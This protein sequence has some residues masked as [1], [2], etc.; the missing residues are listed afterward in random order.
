MTKK[1]FSVENADAGQV[2]EQIGALRAALAAVEKKPVAAAAQAPEAVRRLLEI[3][4]N[5][6]L[7]LADLEAEI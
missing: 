1:R 7:R 2:A 5:I 3:I 6:N 4:E